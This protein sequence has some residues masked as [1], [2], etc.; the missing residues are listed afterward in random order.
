M[1]TTISSSQAMVNAAHRR[2]GGHMAVPRTARTAGIDAGLRPPP[3]DRQRLDPTIGPSQAMVTAAH[4]RS[5]GHMA[6]PRTPRTAW[7]DAGLR[8]LAAGGPDP[9]RAAAPGKGAGGGG[10]RGG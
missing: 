5:G 4:R 9:V 6:V 10:G 1:D 8:A 3:A 2:S 7:I